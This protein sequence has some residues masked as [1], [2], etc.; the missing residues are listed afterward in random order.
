MSMDLFDIRRNLGACALSHRAE[1]RL[2]NVAEDR[3]H[4]TPEA[5]G[6]NWWLML[7]ALFLRR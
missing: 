6:N 3:A 4:A 5:I 1:L 7:K 2:R